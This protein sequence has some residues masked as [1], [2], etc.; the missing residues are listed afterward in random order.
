M[1]LQVLTIPILLAQDIG[2]DFS[3]VNSA[4]PRDA[5]TDCPQVWNG[6]DFYR[7]SW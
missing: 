7:R 3:E 1:L 4:F 5:I 6:E 2:K